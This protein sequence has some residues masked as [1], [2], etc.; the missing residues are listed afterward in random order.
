M[1]TT[2]QR[3][4]LG[5]SAEAGGWARTDLGRVDVFRRGTGADRIRVVWQGSDA[6]SGAVL[7]LDDIMTT[8]TRELATV[9]AWFKR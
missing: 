5:Q 6:I 7:Y 1:T 3:H 2:D 8:Y 4:E 9:N